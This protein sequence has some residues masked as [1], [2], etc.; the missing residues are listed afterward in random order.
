MGKSMKNSECV[1]EIMEIGVL[2]SKLT[3]LVWAA[4]L[5]VKIDWFETLTAWG[6]VFHSKL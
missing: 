2:S 1:R 5:I 3:I 6:V 4:I